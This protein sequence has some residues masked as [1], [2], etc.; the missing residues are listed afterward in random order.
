[1]RLAGI[2]GS[3]WSMSRRYWNGSCRS[4]G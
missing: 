3:R 4:F 2:V 1:M